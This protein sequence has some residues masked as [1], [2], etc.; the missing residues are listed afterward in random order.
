M[1]WVLLP[2]MRPRIKNVADFLS[3]TWTPYWFDAKV[4]KINFKDIS[5]A[6]QDEKLKHFF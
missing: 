4:K 2:E 3:K 5:E 1:A 6:V